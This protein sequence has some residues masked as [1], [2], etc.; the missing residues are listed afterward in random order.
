[1]IVRRHIIFGYLEEDS[2]KCIA[3]IFLNV[4][5]IVIVQTLKEQLMSMYVVR[6]KDLYAPLALCMTEQTVIMVSM[7]HLDPVHLFT[8]ED[9]TGMRD[10]EFFVLV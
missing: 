3:E 5:Y 7:H 2:V 10:L 4:F 8:K 1:M 9:S 6:E